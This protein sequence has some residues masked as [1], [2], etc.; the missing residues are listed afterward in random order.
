M[1]ISVMFEPVPVWSVPPTV[2]PQVTLPGM[3][4]WWNV[5]VYGTPRKFA[6]IIPGPVIVAT[7]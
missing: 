2:T 5:T 1:P 7:A 4:V 3:P 6:V